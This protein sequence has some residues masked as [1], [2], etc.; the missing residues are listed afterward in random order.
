M[1]KQIQYYI[2]FFYL[3]QKFFL[4]L[5]IFFIIY[6]HASFDNLIFKK[7]G[8]AISINEKCFISPIRIAL[9]LS[10]IILGF[11]FVFFANIKAMF[12]D[13]SQSNFQA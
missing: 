11:L 1:L 7:P 2:S 5:L 10:A 8:P 4:F 13:K 12:V 9:I 6:N 3:I